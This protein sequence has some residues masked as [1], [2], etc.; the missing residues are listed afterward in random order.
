MR[1]REKKSKKKSPFWSILGRKPVDT[2]DNRVICPKTSLDHQFSASRSQTK[3]TRPN[4]SD[5]QFTQLNC[6]TNRVS[7]WLNNINNV[8]ENDDKRHNDDDDDD[9]SLL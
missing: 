4:A 9:D 6:A 2:E 7:V 5:A 3:A 8:N 1:G